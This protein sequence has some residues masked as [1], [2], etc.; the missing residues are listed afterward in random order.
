[1]VT[2]FVTKVVTSALPSGFAQSGELGGVAGF[3][4]LSLAGDARAACEK[5]LR[6]LLS[7]NR[8]YLFSLGWRPP[9]A[10]TRPRALMALERVDVDVLMPTPPPLPEAV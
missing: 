6:A 1:M 2:L 8:E 5:H 7:V 10:R 9:L 4:F 3:S